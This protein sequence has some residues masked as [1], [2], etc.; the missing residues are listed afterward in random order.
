LGFD[1]K[2]QENTALSTLWLVIAR[3]SSPLES[4]PTAQPRPRHESRGC[5]Q[6][7]VSET[8]TGSILA[9]FGTALPE[10]VVALSPRHSA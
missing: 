2:Q 1:W 3:A 7:K 9:T 10:S 4:A 6:F 8:A 5:P